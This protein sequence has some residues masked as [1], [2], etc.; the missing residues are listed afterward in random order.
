MAKNAHLYVQRLTNMIDDAI[1]VPKNPLFIHNVF[2]SLCV[3]IKKVISMN[4]G[5]NILFF[6]A[7]SKVD[8]GIDKYII[9]VVEA[10]ITNDIADLTAYALQLIGEFI[11]YNCQFTP[12]LIPIFTF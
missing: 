11:L 7:Y 1:R 8:G 2:E 3:L 4:S 6:Q 9:P 12:L 10:I 5:R